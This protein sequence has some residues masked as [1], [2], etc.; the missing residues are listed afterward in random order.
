MRKLF[1]LVL[2]ALPCSATST[3]VQQVLTTCTNSATCTFTGVT[4]TAGNLGVIQLAANY[5]LEHINSVSGAGTWV[6]SGACPSQSTGT[7]TSGDIAYVLSLSG[8]T[9]TITVTASNAYSN[10]AIFTEYALS[11]ATW[12]V[13]GACQ[14]LNNQAATT[15]PT[16]PSITTTGAD[17]VIVT[18]LA[19]SGMHY[20]SSTVTGTG[21][22]TPLTMF[23]PGPA[24]SNAATVG[25]DAVGVAAGTYQATFTNISSTFGSSL[26]AFTAT[27]S[28]GG[29]ARR[30][31]IVVQ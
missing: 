20:G 1:L 6:A 7:G 28:G 14:T 9:S 27:S 22:T 8:G 30:K 17:D 12:T 13:D 26:M 21:W 16:S 2:L 5:P 15:H 18:V 24:F 4:T 3:R 10:A 25:D 11:G 19:T 31:V 23:F 29:G